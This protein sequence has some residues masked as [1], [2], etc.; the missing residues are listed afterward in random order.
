MARTRTGRYAPS[1]GYAHAHWGRARCSYCSW[2]WYPEA[3]EARLNEAA[4]ASLED[5]IESLD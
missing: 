3:R 1:W 4:S 5:Y 2:G